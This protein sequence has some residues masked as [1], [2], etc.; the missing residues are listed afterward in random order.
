MSAGMSTGTPT[1]GGPASMRTEPPREGH[2][3]GAVLAL[4]RFETREL[5]Q[6]IP[7]LFFFALYVG[8]VVLRLMSRDGMDDFP[9]LNTVDRRTQ[10]APLLFAVALL[11][12]T[13]SAALRSRKHGT[14]QQ[15]DVLPMEPWRRTLAHV[16]SVIPYAALTALVVAAEFTREALKPGAIGH[17]SL[18][19]L[20]V[21]PLSVLMAGITGVL[22]ARL[23]PSPFIPIL[24]VIALYVL[25]TLASAVV[26][27]DGKWMGWLSPILF[28]DS[29]GGDPVPADLLGRPA[30]WHAL[31]V[32]AACV[33]LACAALLLSGGRTRA[34]KAATALA[35]A[36]T[37]AGVIGQLPRDTAALDTARKTASETPQKVQSCTRYGGS[38]Y[39]SFPE[40]KGVRPEWAEVV[41]RLQSLAGG[42]AA[43]APLTVRQRIYNGEEVDA[44][45][46]P[47]STPGEVTVG[48]R[49]G[50]N[51][52][53]EFAVGAASVLVGGSESVTLQE[54]CDAR[55][56]T[57]MW[58]VLGADP[59]PMATFQH[60]RLD[61]TTSG[62]G[63]VLAPTNGL[64]MTAT[65]TAVVR[66]LLAAPRAEMTARV[67]A[68][69]AELTS[70]STT[71]AQAAKLLGVAVPKEA[72]KCEE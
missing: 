55:T 18:G 26:G 42:S 37:A 71:T 40:W 67:K 70:A 39:C 49:W 5:L 72:E 58:L 57:V 34:V 68:H 43:Q 69:W 1:V 52:V 54:M 20:A 60:V 10:V 17:G 63:Q 3:A 38:T 12:C 32:T 35:L 7:V 48:T 13:N 30:G 19:E 8:F 4:A 25:I 56:V 53:P 9:V 15:F 22:L 47:S 28:S 62:S 66:E 16:L 45:L 11:I 6:Q 50:G 27:I 46:D 44:A 2:R 24:F 33:L 14:V 29:S 51:R 65:Q 21:G 36:A 64:S 23:L 31:Y 61:D 41:D 59:T